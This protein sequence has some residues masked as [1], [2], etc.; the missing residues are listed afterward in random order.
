MK[1]YA[2]SPLAVGL[3]GVTLSLTLMITGCTSN[4]VEGTVTG[5]DTRLT[6]ECVEHSKY[7]ANGKRKCTKYVDV[8]NNYLIVAPDGKPGETVE[9]KVTSELF[10]KTNVGSHYSGP[11]K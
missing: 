4:Y 10:D 6:N 1:H 2:M 5:K 9:I 3:S 7:R 8:P 11:A